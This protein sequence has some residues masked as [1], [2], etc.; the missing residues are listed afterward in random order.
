MVSGEVIITT[1][2]AREPVRDLLAPE[3]PDLP[4]LA[5][6]ELSS[7][8]DLQFLGTI[9]STQPVVGVEPA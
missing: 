9:S 5:R 8:V 7:D 3:L 4:I 1:T 2:W 6:G